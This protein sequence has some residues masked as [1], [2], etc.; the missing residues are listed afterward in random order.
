MR[1]AIIKLITGL[2]LLV[3]QISSAQ[4][5]NPFYED[6][7]IYI[8]IKANGMLNLKHEKLTIDHFQFLNSFAATYSVT[9]FRQLYA[10]AKHKGL[11]NIYKISISNKNEIDL[12]LAH[13]NSIKELEYAEKVPY[14]T[15]FATPPNDTSYNNT[16]QWNLFKINAQLAW[17]F[18]GSP[19]PSP[20]IIAVIDDGLDI[21]HID[22]KNNLW[23][24]DVELNGLPGVDDD[25]NFIVDDSLGYDFG[26]F[27]SD[28]SPN[29]VSW[30]H[31]T[32][33]AGI[34][35]AVTNNT[36]GIAS[37]A[38][39]AR[40]MAVKGSS[41]NLYVSNG[42]EAIAYAADN[43]A[44]VINL[45]WGAPVESITESNTILYAYYLGAV[46][47]AAAGNTNDA[48]V[49]Y[50]AAYPHVICVASTSGN[51]T[52][53]IGTTYGQH[54]DVTAPGV[55]IFSTIPGNGF[56][57]MSGTSMASPL[58]AGL[59]ALMK[60][61]NPLLSP[62]QI[63]DCIKNNTD[64]IDFMNPNYPGKLG[65]GRIN[66]FKTMQ[67]VNETRYQIDA[68]LVKFNSPNAFTCT[69]ELVP[70]ISLKNAGTT[71]LQQV[72]INYNIDGGAFT[73]LNWTGDMVYDSV[74]N[75]EFN[76][77]TLSSGEHVIKA[78]CT[79]PNGQLDWNF[80]NDTIEQTFKIFNDGLSLPFSENFENGFELQSWRVDN[81]DDDKSWQVKSGSIDG[82][83]N[84]AAFINLFNYSD[85]GQR[86]GLLTPLLN[87]WGYDTLSLQF[88]YAWRRNFRQESDSLIVSL[89]TDCG[90]TFPYRIATFY[91]D[92]IINF[93]TEIDTMDNYFNPTLSGSWCGNIINC[94][95]LNLSNF[96]GYSGVILKFES[97]N[98]FNNNLFLDNINISGYSYSIDPPTANTITTNTNSIC[99]GEYITFTANDPTINATSWSWSFP[100]GTP[101]TA[102]EQTVTIQFNT[103]GTVNASL[104]VS[105]SN[106][107]SNVNLTTPVG[108]NPIPN[109][110]ILQ[111]DTVIC[112]DNPLILNVTGA[113][114]YV[115]N[116]STGL[117]TNL[118]S[119][120]TALPQQ[121]IVYVVTGTS[122]AGCI[123]YDTISID[124][125]ACLGINDL[126]FNN[127]FHFVYHNINGQIYLINKGEGIEN[128]LFNLYNTLGQVVASNIINASANTSIM[129]MDGSMLSD[130]VYFTSLNSKG[131]FSKTEK[132]V[133][134][135]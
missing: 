103:A 121:N 26:N 125:T 91:Q 25:G 98:N 131:N 82:T 52:K 132:L 96:A 3:Q 19:N 86:D 63:E 43:G 1:I 80:Y 18:I 89:S 37:I 34:A 115:W 64:N 14:K 71:N 20:T 7:N 114:D 133:I 28:A 55:N 50:P 32:H 111:S 87:F 67:C 100:N 72:T 54:I 73:T 81:A 74:L 129:V 48:T 36:T 23:V 124:T 116:P 41:S 97:Y 6:G 53:A 77:I 65:T 76:P 99:E 88:E 109:V 70:S 21:Q 35:G 123:N 2:L 83:S 30:H 120:V 47:V 33:V 110:Q 105:N 62:D 29:D 118:G 90:S 75:I 13:L 106:G 39:N 95:Q 112:H 119:T 93:A 60:T 126:T 127:D 49:N 4:T 27:D 102:N 51:D 46:V 42:Y 78:F 5:V 8:K 101:S 17:N 61:F 58:V 68:S 9:E 135:K 59:A 134:H 56:A 107:S 108:V 117:N 11:E 122:S 31:G 84:K 12:A 10:F 22:L 79:N 45:S 130:G 24:N 113:N 57:L 69:S 128:G 40:L 85:K 104:I 44:D 66:A 94:K 15:Y 16:I 38:Y 92:S